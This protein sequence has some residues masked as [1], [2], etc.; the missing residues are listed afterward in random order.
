MA[1]LVVLHL[2]ESGRPVEFGAIIIHLK[3]FPEEARQAVLECRMPLGTLLATYQMKHESCPQ[4]F[5]KVPADE[6]MQRTL[7]LTGRPLLYGRRNVLLTETGGVLADILEL[8]PPE[9]AV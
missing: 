5:V 3:H 9:A 6:N 8:L 1:R 2:R 4:A 7:G